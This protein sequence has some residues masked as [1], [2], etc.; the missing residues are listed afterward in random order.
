IYGEGWKKLRKLRV[1]KNSNRDFQFDVLMANPP[2][3]GDIKETRILAKYELGKKD[4]GKYQNN[5]GRDILFIERNLSFLKAG[6]RMAV[7]LP[8]GRFNNSSDKQIREFIAGHCRILAVVGL[9]GN[10][11]KPHTGTKTSVLLVQKWDEVLCPKVD[12]YPIFFA[13]MQEPSKDNSGDKIYVSQADGSPLLDTH[14]H[15]IVKHD[16]FNH[17]GLT[18]D[19]IA[20]AFIEF[21]KKEKLSFFDLDLSGFKNLTG[22]DEASL[23]TDLRGFKN[24]AGLYAEPFNE[25]KYRALLERLEISEVNSS[26]AFE[27][28]ASKRIDG[29]YFK[30]KYLKEDNQR[31]HY[32]NISIGELAFVTDGQHGY[33]E[34]DESSDIHHLTAKNA[35]NWFS[36][37][38]GADRIAKWVD[39]NNQRSSL[40]ERDIILSTRGSVGYCALVIP[41]VLPANI[42]Q[43]VARIALFNEDEVNA[44][45]L[46]TYLNSSFGQDWML[47]N[48]SGM[49]QQGLPLAK[50]RDL[51][52]PVLEKVFQTEIQNIIR[53]AFQTIEQS[54]STYTQAETL[55]L[56]A[57]GMAD[58]SPS[59][60]NV[61]IKS[62]KDSF[63]ATG[64]L[65][66]EYYQPK[67]EDYEYYVTNHAKGYTTI[68]DEYA[69]VKTSCK[70]DKE[71]YNYIEISD[72][73]VGD[74]MASFNSIETNELPANAKQE[75]KRGDLL[76][77]K[78]RPNRGAVS[79]ID[80]DN[81]DLIVSGAFTVLR[82]KVDSVFSNETLKVLLRTKIYRDWL[83]K[84]NI[85]T[86][87]PVIRDD[88]ILGLPIPKIDRET[89]TK[90]ATLI[91]QSFT[92]KA[93]SE[94][95]LATAKRAVE[96][97]IETNE[98]TAMKY[99]TEETNTGVQ[100]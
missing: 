83:L 57:L 75:V 51:P 100:T 71:T 44:E 45:Y 35:K 77:S 49:V 32:V 20:E 64:R 13:T 80:F 95:L 47:R 15:L 31:K 99:I 85:G 54:K 42:D 28:N 87:Y 38:I 93:Q 11:F 82:E 46:L 25:V 65:D 17:D 7:V 67:Y 33:H 61:N 74:G 88:D 14:E 2:F 6:G 63:I 55:L 4:N 21:A 48:C 19:G 84:F 3:A 59:T 1:D 70:R 79:I 73:N 37:T 91:Q 8:Q 50:V 18:Q 9:H 27:N 69:L 53:K 34:V 56:N 58:F 60:E 23:N 76:I 72:V 26:L 41:S 43:D 86:Q 81:T 62:F 10:V 16:L 68:G 5:V 36:D 29:E 22:L 12:D 94:Q 97:A 30:K 92:L 52:I 90:I 96:L 40:K 24:L 66:A 98:Q 39:D 89:Q 78:V